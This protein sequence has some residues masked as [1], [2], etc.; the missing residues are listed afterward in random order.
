M[1]AAQSLPCR[2]LSA[3]VCTAVRKR[4]LQAHRK[5]TALYLPERLVTGLMP[6]RAA[7]ASGAS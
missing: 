5:C 1:P 3:K 4:L 2:E 6:A 7:T